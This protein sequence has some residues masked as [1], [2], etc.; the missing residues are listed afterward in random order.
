M[1]EPTPHLPGHVE[2]EASRW[3]VRLD[4]G[5]PSEQDRA[6]LQAWLE[7][8]PGHEAALARYRRLSAGLSTQVP[9]LA[10]PEDVNRLR[11]AYAFRRRALLLG[12]AAALAAV[13]ALLVTAAV[14]LRP[15]VIRTGLG[16][17]RAVAL[18]DGSRLE[19]NARTELEMAFGQRERRV[20][21]TQGEAFFSVA[22]NAA[23]PFLVETPSGII[24][25]T[26]T[27]FNVRCT[28]S[29]ATEVLVLKGHVQVSPAPTDGKPTLPTPVSAGELAVAGPAGLTRRQLTPELGQQVIG[30][31]LGQVAFEAEPLAEALARFAPYS[32]RRITVEPDAT[33]LRVGG[34]YSLDDLDGF[35]VALEQAL[36]VA[37]LHHADTSVHIVRR[38]P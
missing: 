33:G 13:V 3:A 32:S 26:G 12:R 30:W 29:G 17:R 22:P 23:R 31:R 16:E 11:A 7:Q 10:D 15:D 14:W 20:R 28:A 9:V 1:S 38:R 24:R 27:I 19:L 35:L 37:V 5:Q 36:P 4:H 8:D 18:A 6:E 25:V 2:H 21:L 34:R